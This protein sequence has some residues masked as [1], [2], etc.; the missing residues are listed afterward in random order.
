KLQTQC[1]SCPNAIAQ[2]A[3]VAALEGPKAFLEKNRRAF[4]ARRDLVLTRLNQI[5]GLRCATPRG[6]FYAFTNCHGILGQKTRSGA[7][8]ETDADLAHFLLEEHNVA[9]VPGSAFGLAPHLRLSYAASEDAL[10][11][12][13]DRIETAIAELS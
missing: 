8:I 3:A 7:R 2:W 6:A 9:L 5:P 1:T 12:G 4:L 11:T 13:C 10:N